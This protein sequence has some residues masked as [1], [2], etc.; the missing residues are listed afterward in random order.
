ME[1]NK[2]FRLEDASAEDNKKFAEA[3]SALL[4]T[5]PNLQISTNIVKKPISI[6]MDDGKVENVFFDS[7][8]LLIQKKV[9]IVEAEKVTVTEDGAI[10]STNKEVN[11]NA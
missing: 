10:P 5:F 3:F 4:K 7:P 2:K 9:E 6:K 1:D 8:T 11:P